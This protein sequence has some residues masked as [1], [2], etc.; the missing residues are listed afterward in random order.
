MA[1]PL[2]SLAVRPDADALR[3]LAGA[4]PSIPPAV[5]PSMGSEVVNFRIAS[6]VVDQLDAAADA[7]GTTRKVIITRA[8]A[9]AG[10]RIPQPDLEDR[11]PRRR[12]DRREAA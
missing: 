7:E 11:T 10:F 4:N 1:K 6:S 3:E 5:M 12:R 9:R 2:K 8:L